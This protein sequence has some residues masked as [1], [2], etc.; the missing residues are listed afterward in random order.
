MFKKSFHFVVLSFFIVCFCENIFAQQVLI[1]ELMSSNSNIISDEDGDYSDWI[2]IFNAQDTSVNLNG[3]GISDSKSNPFK[4]IF[5]SVVIKPGE[6]LLVFASDKNRTEYV[7]H[8]ETIIDWGDIWKYRLGTSEPPAQWKNNGFDDQLWLAGKSGFGYGDNDDSTIIPTGVNS[9]YVRKTFNVQ[10]LND[11]VSAVLHVDFDDGFVAY[12]NGVEIARD[13]IGT[14]GIPPAYNQSATTYV[15]PRIVFGGKP[16]SYI[17]TN[18]QSILVEGENVLAIQVHNYGTGSSDLTLI[19]FLSLGFNNSSSNQNGANPLLDLPFR[20]LHTNF[21]LSSEGE[22]LQLTNLD[23]VLVDEITFPSIPPDLSFGRKP[24]GSNQWVFFNNS[25][26]GDSNTTEGFSDV[27]DNP[28]VSAPSGFYSGIVSVTVSP[29]ANGGTIYYTLDGSEPTTSSAV[30][31]N[32]VLISSTK[33]LRVKAFNT[34]MIPSKTVTNTYLINFN[35]QLPVFSLSTNPE[36]LFDEETGIYTYG[37]SAETSFPYFGANFW[38]DWEKPVHVEYF[39]NNGTDNGFSMDAGVKIFGN[40]SRGFDQKSLAIFARGRYGYSSIKYKLFPNLPFTEYQAFVLRNSGNDWNSTMLRDGLMTNIVDGVGID[41]QAFKQTVVFLNGEYWGIHNLREKVNEHFLAQHHNLYPDSLD[42]LENNGEVVQGDSTDYLSLISFIQNNS[43]ANS[44]NYEFVKTKI[45]V[46]NFIKYF[47]AEIYFANTDWP[48]NNVKFWRNHLNG[49]WRWI[50]YDTDFGFGLFNYD[51]YKHNT[52]EFATEPNGPDWPNPPWSTL[53]LRKLLENES[54][55]NDFINR[56]SDF[57]NTIFKAA[58]VNEKIT[59]FKSLIEAEIPGH[60]Q[61]WN[62]FDY[63]QWLNNVQRLRDFAN[64]RLFYMQMHFIQKFGLT[65]VAP[66]NLAISD[67]AMGS[68]KI[69]SLLIDKPSWTGSYFYGVPVK[70]IAQ[71]KPGYRFV[72]WEGSDISSIDS[73]NVTLNSAY[74]LTAIFSVDSNYSEPKIVINEINYNSSLSFNTEDWIE[75]YNNS[76]IDIDISGWVFKDSDDLHIYKF[77]NGTILKKNDYL[78]LCID[79]SLFKSHFPEVKNYFGN[80]GFGLSGSGELIRLYNDEMKMM[81]SVVYD[82]SPP[83]PTEPDG[84]GATL[85]LKNPDLDNSLGENWAASLGHG[86]PGKINDVFTEVTDK[87]DNSIPTDFSL[88]QNYPNPFNPTTKIRYS[89]PTLPQ[90][91]PLQG[92]EAKQGWLI[93]LKVYDILGNEVVT[94]VY[95]YQSPGYYEVQFDGSK[96]SSGVYFYRLQTGT[97]VSTKK[98]ILLK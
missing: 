8:W 33:V 30:Y 35:T 62:T 57:Y 34:G 56:F 51:G 77:P 88:E 79:T 26:P 44:A 71:P 61:R 75:L 21:K 66:V 23:S 37:D 86:T 9:V 92:W 48:G 94:L 46:E 70:I 18:L 14:V 76:D 80:T 55:K 87:T 96:L 25:T 91:P 10:K 29:G 53:L 27:T 6:H 45:D 50:M 17:I 93:T 58:I 95:E 22:S 67:T 78:V 5:P 16:K 32:P 39:E 85:S 89:I 41:K 4:W 69:N 63:N 3:Y 28:V 12:L 15:E 83:W 49:K 98:L 82:D 59:F 81:D 47:V 74:N 65:G 13:N 19:P 54:F 42:I 36:N 43:L 11:I 68:I 24:D 7:N 64:Q 60:I 40:W 20:Y 1:N 84:N 72:K 52:L 31:S 73:L 38:K 97:F 2:E 90:S